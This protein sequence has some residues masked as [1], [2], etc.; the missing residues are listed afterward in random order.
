MVGSAW[1]S[2]ST[3]GWAW[4]CEGGGEVESDT[5]CGR[6]WLEC[7]PSRPSSLERAGCILAGD[8]SLMTW[9]QRDY[10]ALLSGVRP[11]LSRVEPVEDDIQ[12]F[13]QCVKLEFRGADRAPSS[14]RQLTRSCRC[15]EKRKDPVHAEYIML[16]TQSMPPGVAGLRAR[17]WDRK[18]A[19][20]R[21]PHAH[22]RAYLQHSV[23]SSS[24]DVAR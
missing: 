23:C 12:G 9:L 16:R 3:E 17:R 1:R 18:V 24:T 10:Q 11:G 13:M 20:F 6:R 2:A 7:D 21:P 14:P 4:A 22:S 19:N 5:G 8:W 15:S